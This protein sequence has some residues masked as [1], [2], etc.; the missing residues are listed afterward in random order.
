MSSSLPLITASLIVLAGVIDDLRT[1]KFHNWLFLVCTAIAFAMS[2]AIGGLSG[3]GTAVS[4]F[5]AGL[6]VLLPLVL[7]NVIGAGDM[8]LLAAFGAAIGWSA[9]LDV[10]IASLV[11]G[12]IFGLVQV[13]L[14][15]QLGAT[16]RNVF[17]IVKMEKREKM[18]LHKIPFTVALLMGWLTHL[19]L[20]GAL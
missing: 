8:K 15:R 4:G 1:R 18:E 20:R 16:L 6:A 2:V 12:A 19:T 3:L 9:T 13:A 11:W 14:K 5:V 17:A 10:A 7:T